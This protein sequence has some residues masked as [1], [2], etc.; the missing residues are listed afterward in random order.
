MGNPSSTK[1]PVGRKLVFRFHGFRVLKP[2]RIRARARD[3]EFGD[4]FHCLSRWLG[5]SGTIALRQRE[6]PCPFFFYRD[7]QEVSLFCLPF[8]DEG[9]TF[10]GPTCFH[11]FFFLLEL[12]PLD[13]QNLRTRLCSTFVALVEGHWIDRT[14]TEHAFVCLFV[15]VASVVRKSNTPMNPNFFCGIEHNEP[16]TTRYMLRGNASLF[17]WTQ[18]GCRD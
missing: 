2:S 7:L 8:H 1:A 14:E 4:P 13:S 15:W 10:R 6:W 18:C 5:G 16:A 3:C 17:H 12:G 9:L 11:F